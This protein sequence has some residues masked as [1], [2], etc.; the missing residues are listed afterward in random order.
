[1][2]IKKYLA[3]FTCLSGK[4]IL[5]TGADGGIGKELAKHFAFLG[6]QLI[7]ANRNQQKT[8][9]LANEILS[10]YPNLK[11]EIIPLDLCSSLS[12]AKF[13]N[14]VQ[15][16]KID[17]FIHNAGI[18]N[19]SRQKTELGF[20][21]IYQTNCLMPYYI[22]KKLLTY[23]KQNHTKVIFMG[24]IAYNYSKIDFND[25]QF[26]NSKKI[27]KIYGNSKRVAMFA[28][29]ELF[30]QNQEIEFSI[31]HPGLTLTQMTNHY[32]K[33]INWLVRVGLK[34]ICPPPKQASLPVIYACLNKTKNNQWIGPSICNIWG[35]PKISKYKLNYAESKKAQASLEKQI[36]KTTL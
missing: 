33:A 27:N 14:D 24:S 5:I 22:T 31:A 19:V 18:Y 21:N 6:C 16:F 17:F 12:V 30:K 23:F 36:E 32:P 20:D 7:F 25:L 4:T 2:N 34:L 9:I 11:I 8:N 13:I 1:M 10:I 35:K 28:L 29:T 3:N 26:I 15:K